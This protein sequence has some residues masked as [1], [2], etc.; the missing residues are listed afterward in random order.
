MTYARS[1]SRVGKMTLEVE[2]FQEPPRNL[3]DHAG[4]NSYRV[5]LISQ[6]QA[7]AN[8]GSQVNQVTAVDDSPST[9]APISPGKAHCGLWGR[10]REQGASPGRT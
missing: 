7:Y 10:S 2:A 6:E 4:D 5:P 1:S 3:A 8:H 9:A